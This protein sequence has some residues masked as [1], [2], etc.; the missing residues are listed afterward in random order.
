MIPSNTPLK[1]WLKRSPLVIVKLKPGVKRRYQSVRE[2]QSEGKIRLEREIQ[3]TKEV[4]VLG[5]VEARTMIQENI[6]NE[7]MYRQR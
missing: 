1:Q 4:K 7:P 2:I 5:V 6:V 3:F